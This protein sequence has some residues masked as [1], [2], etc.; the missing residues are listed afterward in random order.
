MENDLDMQSLNWLEVLN[1]IKISRDW[2]NKIYLCN[3][4]DDYIV[5]IKNNKFFNSFFLYI[6]WKY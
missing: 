2:G 6:I 1:R 3:E 4:K 5:I